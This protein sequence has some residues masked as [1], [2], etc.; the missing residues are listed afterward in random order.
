MLFVLDYLGVMIYG[1]L[2]MVFFLNIKINRK[3]IFFLS[4]Y[5]LLSSSLQFGIDHVFGFEYIERL[6]P[7]I[8]HLPLV[9]FFYYIFKKRFNLVL[10][11][12]FTSYLLTSPRR[13]IGEVVALLFN[14]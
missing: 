2:I 7:L 9:F 6:Y 4:C 12:L 10:F 11:V 1:V 5:M 8:I 13:W 14:N 3:S